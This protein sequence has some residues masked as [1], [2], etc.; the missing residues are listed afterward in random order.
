MVFI[1]NAESVLN[2][3]VSIVLFRTVEEFRDQVL[4]ALITAAR[5]CS[6]SHALMCIHCCGIAQTHRIAGLRTI[7]MMCWRFMVIFCGS[8]IIGIGIALLAA[9][10]MRRFHIAGSNDDGTP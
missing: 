7:T 5:V 10:I 6:A 8:C 3:A 1:H 9:F 4:G 2:D